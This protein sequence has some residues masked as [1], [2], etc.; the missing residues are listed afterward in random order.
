MTDQAMVGLVVLVMFV[1]MLVAE[2]LGGFHRS[3]PEAWKGRGFALAGIASH[4]LLAGPVVALV[5]G[6]LFG[7]V[8]PQTQGAFADVSFWLA[9]PPLFL[10]QELAHYWLHRWSHEKRW[11]WK[12]HRTHHSAEDLNALVLY[13]YNIFW[14]LMLPQVWIGALAVHLGMFEVFAACSL[15]EFAVNALTHTPY[16]WDLAL[17]RVPALDT[18]FNGLEKVVTLPDTHHAHHGLGR[19]ANLRGNYAVTLFFLDMLFGTAKIP[20]ARQE[21]FGLPGRFDW[22]EEL[23]WPVVRSEA[24]SGTAPRG[25]LGS[26]S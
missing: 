12:F 2:A 8:F 3:K 26:G 16:R 21:R 15:I 11:L 24:G 6:L 5:M 1:G 7:R 25:H 17:R 13:R 14:T 19:H 20:R 10:A 22:R 4:A 23:F 18:V 9:F